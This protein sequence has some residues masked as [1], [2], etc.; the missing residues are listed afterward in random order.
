MIVGFMLYRANYNEMG[1]WV[2]PFFGGWWE[3]IV[4][5]RETRRDFFLICRR[6]SLY[7][8]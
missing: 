7:F 3:A 2:K 4:K 8:C 5:A 1:W 6:V